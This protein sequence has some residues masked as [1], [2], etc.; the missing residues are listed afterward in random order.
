MKNYKIVNV[1]SGYSEMS[2]NRGIDEVVGNSLKEVCIELLEEKKD[3]FIEDGEEDGE[4]D[5]SYFE[6]F[7]NVWGVKDKIG[8]VG[9]GEEGYDLI[10]EEGNEWYDK[11][12]NYDN[13]SEEEWNEWVKFNIDGFE[14]DEEGKI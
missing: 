3:S 7:V 4:V 13:W 11:V 9:D 2:I 10:I 5:L 6:E 1:Y 14:F 8:S 12:D